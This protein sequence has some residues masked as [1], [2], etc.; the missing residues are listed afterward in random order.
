MFCGLSVTGEVERVNVPKQ[1][2]KPKGVIEDK[3]MSEDHQ[4]VVQPLAMIETKWPRLFMALTHH[5]TTNGKQLTFAD[6]PWLE[7][8]YKDNNSR[9]VIIKCSQVHMT[10][11]FLCAM[12]TDARRGLRG[13]YILPTNEHRRP[14]VTDRIN[15]LRDNSKQ[16]RTAVTVM[17]AAD[18]NVYK[19]IFG[20]GWKFVGANVRKNFFEFPADVLIMDEYDLLDQDNLQYA[21]DRIAN[22]SEPHV[23]K[24]GN[25]THDGTGIAKEWLTSTQNEWHVRCPHC[26]TEQVLDWYKHFVDKH[27]PAYE[28][29]DE[30][31]RPLCI[32][33]GAPFDRC[34]PGRWIPANPS[35]TISGYRISRLFTHKAETDIVGHPQDS[36]YSKFCDAAGNETRLQNFHNNYLGTT[37]ESYELKLSECLIRLRAAKHALEYES[38]Y[39]TIAGI[40]QGRLFT[41]VISAVVNGVIHDLSYDVCS[42]WDELDALLTAYNV[43]CTV[44]DAQGGGYAE[45]RKF[46]R[47]HGGRWMC[48]YRPKDQVKVEYVL[49]YEQS[50]VNTNRTELLDTMVAEFKNEKVVVRHDWAT[51]CSGAYFSEMQVPKRKMDAGGRIIWTKGV[52]HFFHAAS[53]RT[54]ALAISGMK[55]SAELK[56][57][58]H[59][60]RMPKPINVQDIIAGGR[61]G[62]NGD[63]AEDTPVKRKRSWH[64]G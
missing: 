48:Y 21:Y 45:T 3:S 31:G 43:V 49:D 53:Y 4:M 14:F 62:D 42:T 25:P 30:H 37:Y 22:S 44:I 60:D 1:R 20:S 63:E 29:R 51:A 36:L 15:R 56:R 54:L 19:S 34:G 7:E 17:G 27:G 57:D 59:V 5:R 26:N 24:F 9:M 61:I 46:V 55:N 52:D 33:C 50:V 41:V 58:W 23:Y 47:M 10:E 16:Y 12:F 28:L 2:G 18:S 6:K 13:M 11:H 32:K 8:I 39:R 35:S 40:D 38:G 64:V